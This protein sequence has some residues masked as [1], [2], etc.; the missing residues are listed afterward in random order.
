ANIDR[1]IVTEGDLSSSSLP[2]SRPPCPAHAASLNQVKAAPPVD[3]TIC[4]N[5]PSCPPP[6]TPR[7]RW[8]RRDRL[9]SA[10][11]PCGGALDA[12][13]V[14]LACGLVSTSLTAQI[15]PS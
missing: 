6:T 2:S 10:G 9:Y 1:P 11:L 5:P 4:A 14:L 7:R 3:Q 8:R 15:E 13:A 12:A